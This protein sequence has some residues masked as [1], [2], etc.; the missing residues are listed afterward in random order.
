M[1]LSV[2]VNYYWMG[3]SGPLHEKV[4]THLKT[5]VMEYKFEQR[6]ISVTKSLTD[7]KSLLEVLKTV[8]DQTEIII[9]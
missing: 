1:S 2:P 3:R 8:Q 9:N 5:S 6:E 7:I 4:N